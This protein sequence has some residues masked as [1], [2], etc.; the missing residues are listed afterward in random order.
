MSQN[1]NQY[2]RPN[3]GVKLVSEANDMSL[4]SDEKNFNEEVIFSPYLIAQTYGDRLPFSF[5]TDNTLSVQP[6][7]LSYKQY[8]F[9]NVFVSTNYYNPD[10][11]DLSCLTANTSC[12]IGLTGIDNGLVTG[13][14]EQT[15][16]FTN[17]INDF[18]KFDRLSFDRR[19]KMFQVTGY[20]SSN[21]R[22]SG[23]DKTILYGN[24]NNNCFLHNYQQ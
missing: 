3:W 11:V 9:D 23:F 19:L 14:T 24:S 1:I 22:F 8:N 7:S 16:T 13:M 10:N 4:V 20:T 2:P 18:T 17:G 15:I 5:D 6:L 12:D 21:V